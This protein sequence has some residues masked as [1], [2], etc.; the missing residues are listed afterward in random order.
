MKDTILLT[1]ASG[2]VGGRLLRALESRGCAVRC[3][4]RTPERVRASGP[5]TEVVRGD[6]L[7]EASLDAALANI[8]AAYYLV[9]SMASGPR[10]A[11]LD[12][13]AAA[14]FGR[15][16]ARAGVR[17]IVYLG[18][19]GRE[20]GPLST[21]L[22]SRA[23]TGDALRE[24]GV[25]V[26]ELRA[27]IV[28]GAGSLSFEMIQALVERLPAMVCP[29]WVNTPTQPIAI[30]DV[31][32][33]LI[34]ALDA[35]QPRGGVFEIGGPE[36]VTYGGMMREYARLRGLRRLLVPVPVLTPRLSGLWLRL[37]TPAHAT[38]GRALV[39]GLRTA[40]VVRSAGAREAFRV[41]PTPLRAAFITAI[42]E[43]AA[44]RLKVD[45]RTVVVNVP[46]ARAFAPVS[47][48][49]GA[50][51]W[52]FGNALWT[53]RGWLDRCAGG[54]GM[55]RGRRDAEDCRVGEAIDGWTVEHYTPG[56]RLRLA[57]DLKLPGR[58]WLE[59]EVMP[60]DGGTRSML[61]QTATF[62]PRGVLGR[63]YWYAVLPLHA[64]VF[65]GMIRRIARMGEHEG[66]PS[67]RSAA[68]AVS[69]LRALLL[70]GAALLPLGRAAGQ[71]TGGVGTLRGQVTD[72]AGARVVD[73]AVCVP[74]TAQCAVTD[75]EGRFTLPVRP[76]AHALEVAPPGRQPIGIDTVQVRAGLER[77]VE[78][79]LPPQE[80]IRQT[81]TVTAPA[82]A[83]PDEVKTSGYLIAP[84]EIAVGAGALQDVSRYV[85]AL[86]G[87]AIGSDDFR[88]DL[89]V[90]GGS[91]LENLYIVDNVEVPNINTF[92][93]FAS[94]GGTVSILDVQ[95]IDNV[96]FL[97][98]GYPAPFGNR[99]S[100]VLQIT[101][102]EGRRDRVAGRATLGFAG[103]GG[104]V[105]GPLGSRRQGSWIV[106]ARRSVLDLVTSDV[107]IGGVP[108]LYTLNAK[109]VYDASPRDRVWAVNVSGVDDVRLGLTDSSD[110]QDELSNL[111]IRY[112]GWRAASGVNWQRV[113]AR[114]V[115]LLGITHARATVD[116]RVADLLRNGVPA[117]GAAVADQI[118]G[119]EL[120]FR[121]QSSE[122]ETAVRYD[123]TLAAPF[124][125]KLQAGGA[126]RVSRLDYDAA[127]PF[128]TDSPYFAVPDT[129]PFDVREGFSAFQGGLY[130]QATRRLTARLSATGGARVDRYS[131]LGATRV[132]PRVGAEYML[133]PR[134]SLQASFGQYYQ[135]PFF[136]FLVAYPENR[137]L[138]PFRSDH[139]VGGVRVDL[140][141][142]TRVRLE[143]YWKRY[144]DYPVSSQIPSLSLAN[145]GDTFAVRDVLFP[146]VGSGL[147]A[148]SGVEASVERR[149]SLAS[150]WSGQANLAFS[151][152]RYA[153]LDG[154]LRPGSFDYP[155]V[156]NLS[157]GVRLSGA[158]SVS[159]KMT[160]LAGRPFT[161][162]DP[163][164]ST[165][166]RRAV[167]DLARVNA[168]RAPDYARLD[169][170]VERAF[171]RGDARGAI[172]AGV[173]NVTN[174]DNVAGYSWDRRGNVLR[175]STQLGVFPIAGI[176]WPF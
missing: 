95:L 32:A 89:I 82:Y 108:V 107:G 24:G 74:A 100:S 125:E 16:A 59:F 11:E 157:G 120:V 1:G 76:G 38:V 9:H 101:Q 28:I 6:C 23:E 87:V 2:Y 65:S 85:Q 56:M 98:G 52:Y 69:T 10:F 118:A 79:V 153:G 154:V 73:A 55:S 164:A 136:L 71:D 75:A 103:A 112:S 14:A 86:P 142:S 170:R 42:E 97:T 33:Y 117:T 116:Q 91:P 122:A 131:F 155:V 27:S 144:A 158:W 132:S 7:D 51:G 160:Y 134:A 156:A 175:T 135:Q 110:L 165:A 8:R 133:S 58:G 41:E 34:A 37:I 84:E 12:R 47:R 64:L 146:M 72:A 94:A 127:S 106:S 176:E 54:V 138:K 96:T 61:R 130:A 36:V 105:E 4:A 102:R 26:I 129:N 25:P 81:V 119:G 90:R 123:L 172:F 173:Q 150:R 147:G 22:K 99:T 115:G 128:G 5:R 67:R 93:T 31:I 48:I 148:V 174:R 43:S 149:A 30:D 83:A 62:D 68:R 104:V 39:E 49:G 152:A 159:T 45:S 162:V 163:A 109:A 139:Y 35:R 40:T 137:A 140:D 114:G 145:V 19:L 143:A 21:H 111:D 70:L 17:R 29:R 169:L 53:I 15:A 63:A 46:P 57:A 126:V 166:Q 88:N 77:I 124:L 66:A 50:T 167:Y 78:I 18:G 20:A 80:G 161:P 44:A 60:L 151:R 141:A 92:A 113:Y 171:R 3:L 168:G 13:R 121:E